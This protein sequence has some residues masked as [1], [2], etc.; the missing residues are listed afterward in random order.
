VLRVNTLPAAS[1]RFLPRQHASFG[2]YTSAFNGLYTKVINFHFE[3]SPEI[4]ERV[5]LFPLSLK[6]NGL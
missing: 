3:K 6:F 5:K 4:Q 1:A 2:M